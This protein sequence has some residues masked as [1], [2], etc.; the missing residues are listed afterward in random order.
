MLRVFPIL[1]MDKYALRLTS[2]IAVLFIVAGSV[3]S[4]RLGSSLRFSDERD[5][6]AIATCIT[7][8]G[9]YSL[10]GSKP[11]AYRPP[12]YPLWLAMVR[13][14][15]GGVRSAR[16]TN[17]VLLAATVLLLFALL[18]HE[19]SERAGAIAALL[20]CF[21]PVLFYTAGTLYP[22]TL[23]GF[24]LVAFVYLLFVTPNLPRAMLAGVVMG[25]LA[26]TV[27]TFL[28]VLVITVLLF[29]KRP[30]G[31]AV[32]TTMILTTGACIGVWAV[33]NYLTF[34][35][36]IP[37]STNSGINLL[38]G[39]S[40]K[41][42]AE[43]GVNTDISAYAERARGLSEVQRDAFYR[44]EAVRFIM[45]NKGKA[46]A[47]Y[48]QKVMHHF[49]YRNRLA[50]QAESSTLRDMLMLVTYYPLLAIAA[51][52][53]AMRRRHPMSSLERY[54]FALYLLDALIQAVFFTRIRFRLP[55]DL[56][57]IAADALFLSRLLA[58]IRTR[59]PQRVLPN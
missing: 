42:T 10:N 59:S 43:S 53:L 25:W 11:T 5:Y 20:V 58:A 51:L 17:Y 48:A 19:H 35:A 18:R 56:L 54:L 45:E 33:R 37:F 4:T 52:R 27:P 55:F 57:L 15:G 32:L 1:L 29:Y 23:A 39:N 12:G 14:F 50:T 38:L 34:H 9:M 7:E 22:Q 28:F 30:A 21:Y 26:L 41:A 13:W 49:H 47:L 8:K 46:L 3:Y 6:W 44:R 24:L 2:L 40:P 16:V 31:C 36:F